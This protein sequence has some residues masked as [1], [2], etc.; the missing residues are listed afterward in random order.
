MTQEEILNKVR[1]RFA[2]V[3]LKEDF[4]ILNIEVEPSR[5]HDILIFFRDEMSFDHMN[6]M[7]SI[8]RPEDNIVE[9]IYRLFS[10][11]TKDAVVIRVK[12][13]RARSEIETVSDIY[14]TAEWH[15]RE[16]SEMFGITFKNHP[17]PRLLL[18]PDGF[19]GNPLRKDFTH[20]NMIPMSGVK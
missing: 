8:D 11:E 15:E 9:V 12:L 6:F 2:V 7:T 20:P 16:A 17:D 14:R 10:Y 4:G 13:D 19:N 1:S 3:S 5:I 18:L